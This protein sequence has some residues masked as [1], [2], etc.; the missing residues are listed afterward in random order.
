MRGSL[1]TLEGHA[2]V[3]LVE[4]AGAIDALGLALR[5]VA[6]GGDGEQSL[7]AV[8]RAAAA[9]CGAELAVVRLA[10]VGGR[11]LVA[12]AVWAGSAA[13]AAQVEATRL[14]MGEVTTP[15]ATAADLS[16]DEA[17][18]PAA[19]L[20]AAAKAGAEFAYVVP[21]APEGPVVGTLELYR[22]GAAFGED[23]LALAR[24]AAAL[25]AVAARLSRTLVDP[26][27]HPG[28]ARASLD[29]LGDALAAG[30]DE[31]ETAEYVV[32]LAVEATGARAAILWRLDPEGPPVFLA[33][34]GSDEKLPDLR[35]AAEQVEQAIGGRHAANGAASTPGDSLTSTIALGEPP[36]GALQL[37]FDA[38]PAV[39]VESLGVF[40]ARAGVAL[41]RT[42]RAQLLAV[43]LKRS[44]TLVAVVSQAIAQLSLTHTLE[45][46]V[47]RI[48]ELTG[49][50]QVAVYLRE[51]ERLS[52]AAAR[53]LDGRH[54]ELAERLLELALGPYRS[55]GFLFVEDMR[56]EPRL[57]GLEPILEETGLRRA[58]VIPLLVRDEVIGVLAVFKSRPRGYRE[59]EEGLLLALSSQLAVAVQNAR[60]HERTKELGSVLERTLASERQA[61]RQLR[62]LFEITHSF[63]RSLSLAETIDAVAKTMVELFDLDAAAI[64]MPDERQD[65]LETR[66]IHVAEPNLEP[67]ARTILGQP[68]PMSAPLAR[69]LL[70]ARA[71]VLL[72]PGSARS[73]DAH[74]LLEPFLAKGSTAA[75]L[76]MATSAGE[77]LGTITLLS[78]DPTRPLDEAAVEV[79]M[80]VTS[81][82]ALA[83]DN[84]R[85]SQ[86]QKD[87]SE[88]MQ[89]SLLPQE[90]PDVPG[91][92][93]GHVYESS[94][95]VDV[96]GDLY[97][98]LPLDDGRLA[99]VLGDVTGKGIQ[100]A[101]DMAMAKFVFR[102]L[103]RGAGRPGSFLAGAND[104]V[105]EE[106]A[107]GKFITMLCVLVDPARREAIC[108]SAGHPSLRVLAPDGT[109]SEVA[110]RGLALGIE[111]GQSY[112]EE[113]LAL[114]PGTTLVLYTDGVIEV[115][116]DGEL[117]GEGRLDAVL[118]ANAGRSAQELAETIAADCRSFA[119][120][121]LG[122]D[123]AIVCIQLV[124]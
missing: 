84:A 120:G 23:E 59:G 21:V 18:L 88:M 103:A 72:R 99:V 12:R 114:E 124:S 40:A 108:A 92:E 33:E 78:L 75:V 24:L 89:R 85:L 73:G 65:F 35:S 119:G 28:E 44:Q 1:E 95:R 81:Q 19:V 94:A 74:V 27:A 37:R 91:L 83:I 115:R 86:Q 25:V 15:E 10:P 90:L 67:A 68:Q 43:A 87:F 7:A 22:S 122:D 2:G 29:L 31:R 42:R 39:D 3:A 111:G 11:E 41:R 116:R 77:V 109:V 121:E 20:D 54:A 17:D 98:F 57:G 62:G 47:E 32:R 76:P 100:A 71:P 53:G 117:Y 56:A 46:A 14:P 36:A 30:S 69:R 34:Y 106:I 58:L 38:P 60:L 49:S 113:H 97:D 6:S 110:A 45:T 66:S 104:V 9:G 48:S 52:A 105:V 80:T 13:L 79:A 101:A 63:A 96:G 64:R 82:A 118:T 112:D 5:H 51:G 4:G 102:S 26:D 61:A 8:A 70:R 50:G 123:C 16:Q 55:R 107:T 93:V